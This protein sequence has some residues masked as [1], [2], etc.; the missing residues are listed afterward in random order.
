MAQGNILILN[1]SSH[2]TELIHKFCQSIGTVYSTVNLDEA[3]S[4][5]ESQT[6]NLV[7][8]DASLASY[9]SLKGLFKNTTSIV[10]TGTNEKQLKEI[11]MEWPLEHYVDYQTISFE[12]QDNAGLLRSLKIAM[13]YSLLKSEAKNL[14]KSMNLLQIEMKE[15]YSEV[16]DIMNFIRESTIAELEKRIAIEEKYIG[17]Q[18][19][20]LKL[21]KIL[22]KIYTSHDVTNFF[23]VINDIKKIIQ[24]EGITIY[25]LDE[26]KKL[27]KHLKP[28]VWDDSFLTHKDFSSHIPIDSAE[29]FAASV[30]RYGKDIN[31]HEIFHDKR[32]SK[33]YIEQTKSPLKSIL[34]VP[35][36][37][38]KEIIGVTEVYNKMVNGKIS[39]D[40]FSKEDLEI[41]HGLS[42]HISIAMTN[43]NFIQYDPLT[44]LL[45]GEAFL[46]KVIQKINSRR[47]RRQEEGSFAIVMGDVDWFKNYNDRN[48][49]EAGNRLLRQLA[50]VLK[51]SIREEDLLCRYGGEEFLFCLSGIMNTEEACHLT[52]RIRKNVEERYFEYQEFQPRNNLT[53]SFGATL[54]PESRLNNTS[55]ITR[56]ELIKIIDQ[57]DLALAEA[58]GKKSVSLKPHDRGKKVVT[59]NKVC[60]YYG[61][62]EQEKSM[63]ETIRPYQENIFE[64]KRKFKRFYTSTLLMYKEDGSHR[65][66]KTI[67]LSLGGAKIISDTEFFVTQNLDLILILGKKATHFKGEVVYAGIAPDESSQYYIGIKFKDTSF[68]DMKILQDFFHSLSDYRNK[69]MRFEF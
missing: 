16:K 2:E 58:K 17:F 24:A 8:V 40:G 68:S 32:V 46:E 63:P 47:K 21:E 33:R 51:S 50:K 20:K 54:I 42:E 22:R 14:K 48:G 6:C 55:F 11:A 43:L 36:M 7:V 4:I 59:K 1:K 49:H 28:L 61:S 69:E 26:S 12:A 45:R 3:I 18:K 57:A 53:M 60:A 30:A 35:I 66:T 31:I 5:I 37:H 29:D 34:C 27:G 10:I 67:N 41:L 44:G 38:D 9:A 62:Y 23:D 65:V 25:I 13:E 15:A 39:K 19:E 64:E 56:D 52:E